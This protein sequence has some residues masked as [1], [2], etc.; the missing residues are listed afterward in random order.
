MFPFCL[1]LVQRSLARPRRCVRT[2]SLSS[3][4]F[5]RRHRSNSPVANHEQDGDLGDLLS[6]ELPEFSD[7]NLETFLEEEEEEVA[8]ER[9]PSAY[10][11]NMRFSDWLQEVAPGFREPQPRKWLGGEVVSVFFLCFYLSRS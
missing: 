3:T 7:K 11:P 4:C 10:R 9:V 2:F 8:E 5:L 1:R 6:A